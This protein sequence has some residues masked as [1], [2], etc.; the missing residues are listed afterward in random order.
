MVLMAGQA[1]G[2]GDASSD[3]THQSSHKQKKA[4]ESDIEGNLVEA[5]ET[6]LN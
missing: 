6:E 4:T 1:V 3:I 5:K 2:K